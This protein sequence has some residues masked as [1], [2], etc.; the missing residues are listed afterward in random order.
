MFRVEKYRPLKLTDITGNEET[1][2][3]LQ[4]GFIKK[5]IYNDFYIIFLVYLYDLWYKKF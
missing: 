4:V 5:C 1:V 2:K 3:R